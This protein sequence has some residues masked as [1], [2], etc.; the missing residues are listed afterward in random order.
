MPE[1]DRRSPPTNRSRAEL[2]R[3]THN[4]LDSIRTPRPGRSATTRSAPIPTSMHLDSALNNIL[5]DSPRVGQAAHSPRGTRSINA[6]NL[7]GSTAGRMRQ[8]VSSMATNNL[9]TVL[10]QGDLTTWM[11]RRNRI[12]HPMGASQVL[13]H[14]PSNSYKA[15]WWPLP[16]RPV[17]EA[18]D[19]LCFNIWS[20]ESIRWVAL[21]VP[22]VEVDLWFE[23]ITLRTPANMDWDALA[24]LVAEYMQRG[25]LDVDFHTAHLRASLLCMVSAPRAAELLAPLNNTVVQFTQR[26]F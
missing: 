2:T 7:T 21:N 12:M 8:L 1:T 24:V 6:D 16:V 18:D 25:N 19:I 20:P 10:R 15:P 3:I 4:W 26:Q 13:V 22:K 5:S 17:Y 14:T 11:N 9:L 23:R